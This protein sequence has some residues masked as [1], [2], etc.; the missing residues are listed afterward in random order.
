M[1]TLD[2]HPLATKA[3]S[4]G[5]IAG[6]GDLL[7]QYL[8]KRKRRGEIT[9]E[10]AT[11]DGT[12]GGDA[13]I[14]AHSDVHSAPSQG[15]D[16]IRTLRFVTLGSVLVAPSIHAWYG[17]LMTRIP[18]T[19]PRAVMTRLVC[20][21]GFFSPLFLPTFISCLTVLERLSPDHDGGGNNDGEGA[22]PYNKHEE[23]DLYTH[24]STRLINDVPDIMLV[25]WSVWIPGMA[26]MFAF[27]P[28]KF[29]VLYSNC[30]GFAWNAYLSW[31]THEGEAGAAEEGEGG[32]QFESGTEEE[33]A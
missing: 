25:N 8:L 26:V 24:L 7:C 14:D 19:G 22:T 12:E 28:S 29:Q 10:H 2:A 17:F 27:V 15:Y 18:G 3:V 20:D 32:K 1:A 6:S 33:V 9:K 23:E 5:L 13:Q 21:Q 30:I 16:W 11:T 4:S 31:R